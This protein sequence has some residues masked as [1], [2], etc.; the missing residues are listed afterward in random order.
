MENDLIKLSGLPKATQVKD[1]DIMLLTQDEV[2]K[3][4]SLPILE[5]KI[6]DK[7]DGRYVKDSDL[8]TYLKKTEANDLYLDKRET[9]ESAKGSG[10][11]TVDNDLAVSGKEVYKENRKITDA[12]GIFEI[13]KDVNIVHELVGKD[14]DNADYWG[15][16]YFWQ[17]GGIRNDSSNAWRYTKKYYDVLKGDYSTYLT[18]SG[19]SCIIIYDKNYNYIGFLKNP[20]SP[21][22]YRRDISVEFD[23]AR[24]FRFAWNFTAQSSTSNLKFAAKSD[25]YSNELNIKEPFEKEYKSSDANFTDI[26]KSFENGVLEIPL[27]IEN[28][29]ARIKF[30]FK[31]NEDINLLAGVKPFFV[32]KNGVN[33]FKAEID[34][35]ASIVATDTWGGGMTATPSQCI[36]SNSRLSISFNGG[37]VP[38]LPF[39]TSKKNTWGDFLFGI[40]YNTDV[41]TIE[42]NRDVCLSIT[43]TVFR[44]YKKT[45][46]VTLFNKTITN[47]TTVG[48]LYTELKALSFLD[49][50]VNTTENKLAKDLI[51]INEIALSSISMMPD[52][53]SYWDSGICWI[54]EAISDRWNRAEIVFENGNIYFAYNGDTLECLSTVNYANENTIIYIG[55]EIGNSNNLKVDIKDI[56]LNINYLADAEVVNY[57]LNYPIIANKLYSKKL[58]SN[59]NPALYIGVGHEVLQ[60]EA[61][62]IPADTIDVTS[63]RLELMFH[64]FYKKGYVPI[65]LHDVVRWKYGEIELPKR[66]YVPIFDD[67]RWSIFM[68]PRIRQVFERYNVKGAFA[69][70]TDRAFDGYP[71]QPNWLGMSVEAKDFWRQVNM[72]GWHSHSHT[73]DHISPTYLRF[74]KTSDMLEE[75]EKDYVSAI[76]AGCRTD[77]M[78]YP[79]GQTRSTAMYCLM[80]TPFKI[81]ILTANSNINEGGNNLPTMNSNDYY[82]F[83]FEMGYRNL[84]EN[85]IDSIL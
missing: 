58:I 59:Y 51:K 71:T 77:V 32:I 84:T 66:C 23:K 40:R 29:K 4:L 16:G 81:A 83:R 57:S 20:T 10:G 18:I 30:D 17:D 60:N 13:L 45:G 1:T 33:K 12:I 52:K 53:T 38:I 56:H 28:G 25:Y 42:A 76:K 21:T 47:T 26:I 6:L 85:L 27:K 5:Q 63:D 64:N 50:Y 39:S 19:N 70:I 68:N 61:S 82:L 72:E 62:I 35:K 43:S 31:I 48:E 54:A 9:A 46:N 75:L 36:R 65:N 3:Q 41:A 73:R 79:Q 44:I 49:C 14:K 7:T 22:E 78:T 34:T 69:V 11:I 24:Y 15:L 8:A 67:Y 74:R 80:N 37:T 2:S 55:G